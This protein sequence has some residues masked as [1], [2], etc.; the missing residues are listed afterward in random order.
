MG[1]GGFTVIEM[2]V[3]V[4]LF[5]VVMVVSAGAL[6]SLAS[7]NRKAQALQSVMNNLNTTLD[8]MVRAMREGYTY[9]CEPAVAGVVPGKVHDCMNGDTQIAFEPRGGNAATQ[10]QH[11]YAFI[12]PNGAQAGYIQ[13]SEDGGV[14][15]SRVTAPE[16]SIVDMKF[17][18]IGTTPGDTVQPKIV[19]EVKGVAGGGQSKITS[20]FH[21]QATAVQRILDI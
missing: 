5:A 16:I 15:W 1:T 2:M 17:Y 18:V 6:L 19:I 9:D 7:A 4:A 11:A 14:T 21:I 20:T 12:A 10:D 8:S 13:R 3:S